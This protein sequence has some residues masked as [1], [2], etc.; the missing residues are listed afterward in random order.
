MQKELEHTTYEFTFIQIWFIN[1]VYTVSSKNNNLEFRYNQKLNAFYINRDFILSL[2]GVP[3][4]NV[5]TNDDDGANDDANDATINTP[6]DSRVNT[7]DVITT[8]NEI[9]GVFPPDKGWTDTRSAHERGRDPRSARR[10]STR[11]VGQR[12]R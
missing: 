12:G 10:S 3:A 7:N 6:A 8:T 4:S 5:T 9:T 1:C 11:S 2:T